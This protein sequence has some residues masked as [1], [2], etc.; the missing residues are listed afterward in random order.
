VPQDKFEPLAFCWS[1]RSLSAHVNHHAGSTARRHG[2]C[3]AEG[4]AAWRP[5]PQCPGVHG[6]SHL[7]QASD[8]LEL[9]GDGSAEGKAASGSNCSG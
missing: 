5:N 4:G 7:E 6:G 9:L 2:W 3:L 1:S 8:G